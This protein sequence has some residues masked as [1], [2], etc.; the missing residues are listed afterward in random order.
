MVAFSSC[1]FEDYSL[2]FEGS[3][4]EFEDYSLDFESS[5][6][7]FEGSSC[8]FEDHSLNFER[9]SCCILKNPTVFWLSGLWF[10][11]V[12]RVLW[13][14]TLVLWPLCNSL[15]PLRWI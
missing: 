8:E 13:L 5:S 6:C 2:N 9:S 7:K 14:Q 11:F 4:C 10:C 12:A 3:S 15:L 1:E